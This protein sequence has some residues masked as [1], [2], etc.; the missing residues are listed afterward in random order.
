MRNSYQPNLRKFPNSLA[1]SSS[2]QSPISTLGMKIGIGSATL[3]AISSAVIV[4]RTQRKRQ[5]MQKARA[6]QILAQLPKPQVTRTENK[7]DSQ[8]VLVSDNA[9]TNPLTKPI[10][11]TSAS[12]P[13]FKKKLAKY[14]FGSCGPR[15]FLGTYTSHL[16]LE[17]DLEDYFDQ[18]AIVFSSNATVIVSSIGSVNPD[19]CVVF[20]G[21]SADI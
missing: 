12:I 17:K 14:G 18:P 21:A 7:P 5:S 11:D 6:K 3:L 4:L 10:Y 2:A 8:Q 20:E 13:Y 1:D 15:G 16:L 9:Q 19:Y